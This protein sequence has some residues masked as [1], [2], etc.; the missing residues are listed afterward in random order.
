MR[1]EQ[2]K[3][4]IEKQEAGRDITNIVI[5]II[6]EH[7]RPQVRYFKPLD[8]ELK[9]RRDFPKLEDFEK[10]LVFVDKKKAHDILK[11]IK[12]ANKCLIYGKPASGKTVFAFAFGRTF[13]KTFL[14]RYLDLKGGFDPDKL[15]QE[16]II[17]NSSQ[18]LYIID[19][20]HIWP[21]KVYNLIELIEANNIKSKFLFVSR[22]IKGF[23]SEGENYFKLLKD[24]TIQIKDTV[25]VF[26]NIIDLYEDYECK[27]LSDYIKKDYDVNRIMHKCGQ[28]L[29]ILSYF[30]Y[31]W[32]PK[33]TR[34]SLD[35]VKEEE[36]LN[37]ISEKYLEPYE[38]N[39]RRNSLLVCW[40]A[41]YQFEFPIESKFFYPQLQ[42]IPTNELRDIFRE[43]IIKVQ[44]RG[45]ERLLFLPHSTFASLILKTAEKKNKWLLKGK[46]A[47]DYTKEICLEYLEKEPNYILDL[48]HLLSNNNRRD[49][50]KGYIESDYFA[51]KINERLSKVHFARI[52][53]WLEFLN[54]FEIDESYKE[55]IFDDKVIKAVADELKEDTSFQSFDW[56]LK[57]L[58]EFDNSKGKAFFED[59]DSEVVGDRLKEEK[60]INIIK[61]F[62]RASEVAVGP[63]KCRELLASAMS[64]SFLLRIEEGSLVNLG[65]LLWYLNKIDKSSSL[66]EYVLEE[67]TAQRLA[68]IF[69]KKEKNNVRNIERIFEY[70]NVDFIRK[71]TACFDEEF[72]VQSYNHSTLSQISRFV[73]HYALFCPICKSAYERFAR[74]DLHK[75]LQ[76]SPI[77]DI[78]KFVSKI[79]KTK[80]IGRELAKSV[81]NELKRVD[82]KRNISTYPTK[83]DDIDMLIYTVSLFDNP[84]FVVHQLKDVLN[85]HNK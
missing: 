6:Q 66:N 59:L 18:I 38:G 2:G 85:R 10:G 72:F 58:V 82:M 55:K 13:S 32:N 47:Y 62:E 70:A 83:S 19:N 8:E 81:I 36:I 57:R 21:E 20:C 1:E 4:E 44:E 49:I 12:G 69:K 65:F 53:K 25:L 56:F 22:N 64:E 27:D 77:S 67:F 11:V 14:V 33:E 79:G 60:L 35:E 52:Q 45:K 26:K 43:G 39:L 51:E 17:S 23:L 37:K 71:F 30:L 31:A 75:K 28:D 76:D 41:L 46:N 54:S 42:A 80:R 50:A 74:Q 78:Q 48:V 3:F 61:F 63:E 40:S 68:Q 24:Y 84:D 34:R 29:F 16:V 5:Q 15:L 9:S 7:V 73:R